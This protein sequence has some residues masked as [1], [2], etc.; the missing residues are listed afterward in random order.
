VIPLAVLRRP[1][2]RE[3]LRTLAGRL[4]EKTGADGKIRS[5]EA[6]VLPFPEESPSFLRGLSVYGPVMD[7]PLSKFLFEHTEAEPVIHIFPRAVLGCALIRTGGTP[8]GAPLGIRA[9]KAFQPN[10][11]GISFRAA[12]AANMSY[13]PLPGDLS[14]EWKTGKP[15]WLPAAGKTGP[16]AK[17]S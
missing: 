6:A 4:R 1:L 9:R 7:L 5:G 15:A 11:G 8:D 13:S 17:P 10:T 3:E 16:R 12:F 2:F 14:F